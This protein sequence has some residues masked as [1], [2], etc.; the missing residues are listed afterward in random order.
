M[1]DSIAFEQMLSQLF[2]NQL[3]MPASTIGKENLE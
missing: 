2:G 3:F 1:P